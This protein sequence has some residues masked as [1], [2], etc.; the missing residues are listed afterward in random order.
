MLNS[1]PQDPKILLNWSWAEIEPHYQ[2]LAARMLTAQ[3]VTGWLAD[4]TALDDRVSEMYSRLHV[5]TTVNTADKDAEVR[6]KAFL[7]NIYPNVEAAEQKLREKLLVTGIR[8]AA[9]A[10]GRGDAAPVGL[11][12]STRA[13]TAQAVR[14][15]RRV[16][17]DCVV[18][19]LS[20]RFAVRRIL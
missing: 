4:W 2:D 14:Q 10:T 8:K 11:S 3:N 19:V 6:F 5:A 7:D 9:Q 17:E 16:E 18:R 20:R 13:R 12:R 1:L 15:C